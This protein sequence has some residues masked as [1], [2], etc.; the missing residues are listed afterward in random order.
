MAFNDNIVRFLNDSNSSFTSTKD[1]ERKQSLVEA[2]YLTKGN[3]LRSLDLML[4]HD[5]ELRNEFNYEAKRQGKSGVAYPILARGLH[6]AGQI[7]EKEYKRAAGILDTV[8]DPG[9]ANFLQT[10]VADFIAET[11]DELGLIA[12]TVQKF[13]IAGEGNLQVPVFNPK[14]K[15]TFV[16]NTANYTDLG[17]SIEG[18]IDSILLNPAKV[19]AYTQ[20]RPD[21]LNKLSANRLQFI[22]RIL[23]DAQAR[24]YDDAILNG[25]GSSPNPTGMNQNALVG[26]TDFTTGSDAF[27]TLLN[28]IEAIADARA[29]RSSDI[30]IYM[31]TSAKQE[32]VKIEKALSNDRGNILKTT[33]GGLTI[34]DYPVVVTDVIL[35]TDVSAGD[36]KTSRVTVGYANQY[37]WANSKAP[38]VVS[39]SSVG[40]LS[41][42]E[43]V[44]VSGMA[45]GKPAFNNAF[46]YFDVTTAIEGTL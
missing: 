28:G 30:R 32:F 6:E 42:T 2:M 19:G 8:T 3:F 35:N 41:E 27:E 9:G 4:I 46:A 38:Q 5:E 44:R 29:G 10:T 17:S 11:V 31:N 22:L 7:D 23:A 18:G 33:P 26:D 12:A 36:N 14:L 45:D 39:D 15:S 34:A 16:A 24:A 37:Y 13:D 1:A 40:F 25:N 20:I 21:Y 43:T